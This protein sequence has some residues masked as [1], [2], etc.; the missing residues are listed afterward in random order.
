MAANFPRFFLQLYHDPAMTQLGEILDK[1]LDFLS[2]P[3]VWAMRRLP[4]NEY[5]VFLTVNISSGTALECAKRALATF[6]TLLSE[7]VESAEPFSVTAVVGSGALNLNPARLAIVVTRLTGNTSR[8]HILAR[9]KEG[10]IE[11]HAAEKA[12]KRIAAVMLDSLDPEARL[13]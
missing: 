9:A 6:P 10:L 1:V 13:D 7:V 5:E 11:Q 3:A 2:A 8:L 4:S 12:A